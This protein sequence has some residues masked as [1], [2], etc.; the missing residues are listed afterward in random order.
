MVSLFLL[1]IP[2]LLSLLGEVGTA[3]I[4]TFPPRKMTPGLSHTC[5][6]VGVRH[7]WQSQNVRR[8]RSDSLGKQAG[9]STTE[10]EKQKGNES[11]TC[12]LLLRLKYLTG[13]VMWLQ[14]RQSHPHVYPCTNTNEASSTWRHQRV[15]EK[16]GSRSKLP[17]FVSSSTAHPLRPWKETRL[18][19]LQLPCL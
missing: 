17:G 18:F 14:T 9:S 13:P 8:C 7:Q 6:E 16:L 19:V 1:I 5:R 15:C 11:S 3:I 2:F 10:L 4:S 12:S